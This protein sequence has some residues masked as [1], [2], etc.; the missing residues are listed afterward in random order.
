[1]PPHKILY[2]LGFRVEW[3]AS[4]VARRFDALDAETL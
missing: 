3:P 1:M 4:P 2:V